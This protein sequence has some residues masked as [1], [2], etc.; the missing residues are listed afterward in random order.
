M[1]RDELIGLYEVDITKIY[2]RT[3]HTIQHQWVGLINPESK[4][5]NEITGNLKVS[6]NITGDGD[7][8]V[9]LEMPSEPE[10]P[11]AELIMPA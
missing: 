8:K 1:L 4:N 5:Y 7:K 6:L 10:D 2:F 11:N 3:D 9:L